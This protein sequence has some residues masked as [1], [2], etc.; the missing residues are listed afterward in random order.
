MVYISFRFSFSKDTLSFPKTLKEKDMKEKI[1]SLIYIR[2]VMHVT[3]F[4]EPYQTSLG[5][6]LAEEHAQCI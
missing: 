3:N 1:H 4:A 5:A 2:T 6:I